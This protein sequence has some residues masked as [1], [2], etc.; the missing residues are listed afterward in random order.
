[1]MTTNEITTRK[2]ELPAELVALAEQAR[3]YAKSATAPSTKRA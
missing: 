3:D 2:T 1:M